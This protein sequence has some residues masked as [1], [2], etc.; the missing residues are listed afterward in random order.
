MHVQTIFKA[1]QDLDPKNDDHWTSD[2]A[3]RLD[4]LEKGATETSP[5]LPGVTRQHL[6]DVAP[7]FNRKNPTTPDLAAEREA[8][9][10]AMKEAND[11]EREFK[12]KRD[13]AARAVATGTSHE[14]EI[15]DRHTLTRQNRS[16]IKSQLEGDQVR[17]AHQ[18]TIDDAVRAS[19]GVNHAGLHPIDR[20]TAA[21]NKAA[22]RNFVLP[23]PA[24]KEA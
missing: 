22:R 7:L 13:A 23:A 17:A 16:W 3:P 15:R 24:K 18:K 4:V 21:R 1:L 10:L 14:K 19:G 12:E 2:N 8:A 6:R 11:A 9:E 20:N 5:P